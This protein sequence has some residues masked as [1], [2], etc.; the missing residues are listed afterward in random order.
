MTRGATDTKDTKCAWLTCLDNIAFSLYRLRRDSPTI[1]H[2]ETA[3][4]SKLNTDLMFMA[5]KEIEGLGLRLM[6]TWGIS[7]KELLTWMDLGP[8]ALSKRTNYTGFI[9]LHSASLHHGPTKKSRR[10]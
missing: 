8:D 2:S 7:R 9:G 6:D 4:S 10:R 3:K 5:E 1:C